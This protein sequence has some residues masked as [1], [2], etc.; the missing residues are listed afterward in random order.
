MD[1]GGVLQKLRSHELLPGALEGVQQLVTLLGGRPQDIF[2]VS[3]VN[4]NTL[5]TDT[6]ASLRSTGFFERTG[7][8]ERNYYPPTAAQCPKAPSP[9]DTP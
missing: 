5:R 7:I 2:I 3:R 6:A 8:P 1:V 9:R 4:K